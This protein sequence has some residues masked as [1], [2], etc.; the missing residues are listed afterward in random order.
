VNLTV[1]ICTDEPFS[2]MKA[3][4]EFALTLGCNIIFSQ[5]RFLMILDTCTCVA[6]YCLLYP[7]T[8]TDELWR[9]KMNS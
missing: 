2:N 4:A 1:E 5:E 8:T 3:V 7:A 9:P 6:E